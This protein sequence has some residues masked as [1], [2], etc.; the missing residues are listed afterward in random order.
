VSACRAKFESRCINEDTKSRADRGDMM[1]LW[2]RRLA[3]VIVFGLL[4]VNAYGAPA[5]VP[6]DADVSTW[7]TISAK[8]HRAYQIWV[9]LPPGYNKKHAPYPVLYAADANAEFSTVIGAARLLALDGAIPD[10]VVVGIGYPLPGQGFRASFAQRALDLTTSADADSYALTRGVATALGMP[11]PTKFGGAEAFLEFLSA[12]LLPSIEK[13]Y[14]VSSDD[15][16]WF[17]HSL[18]GLFGLYA[19][20]R[21]DRLFQRYLIGSPSLWWGHDQMLKVETHFAQSH[22]SLPVRLFLSVGGDEEAMAGQHMVSNLRRL[23]SQIGS[24]RYQGLATETQ[25]F[26]GDTHG[27]V[28]PL[29]VSRGLRS[30]FPRPDSTNTIEK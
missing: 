13:K 8:S 11:P 3:V 30:L 4:G 21:D 6:Y 17:G 14:N 29:T 12:E 2:S 24:H 18:G 16:G 5:S 23:S 27:S 26:N 20:F 28:I 15:R 10:L 19:M 1:N 9:A 25:V 22:S 7:V